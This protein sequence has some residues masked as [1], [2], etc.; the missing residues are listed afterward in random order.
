MDEKAHLIADPGHSMPYKVAGSFC[1]FLSPD[2]PVTRDLASK[3]VSFHRGIRLEGVV[4]VSARRRMSCLCSPPLSPFVP[5]TTGFCVP[6]FPLVNDPSQ[7][8]PELD[9]VLLITMNCGGASKKSSDI[10]ALGVELGAQVIF[11]QE[12]WEAF[13]VHDFDASPFAI[14]YDDVAQRGAGLAILVHYTFAALSE[15]QKRPA[16]ICVEDLM[17]LH[18]QRPGGCAFICAN[19][20]LR[21]LQRLDIWERIQWEVAKAFTKHKGCIFVMAG[22][23][24]ESISIRG[25][26]KVAR[27]LRPNNVWS[28]LH[29]PYARGSATNFVRRGSVLSRKEID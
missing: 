21:P 19:V 3:S 15:P 1:P 8:P 29:V 20:Y 17:V 11:L 6:S 25:R 18:L 28:F 10:I 12:L 14:F 5:V 13:D 9:S 16:V 22:D 26:G 7:V 23:L 2:T 27:A 24:N 4:N